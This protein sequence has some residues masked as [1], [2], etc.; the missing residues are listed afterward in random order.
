MSWIEKKRL[1]GLYDKHLLPTAE[2]LRSRDVTFFV[3]GPEDG[4]PS[5]P[6]T[7]S[8]QGDSWYAEP[9]TGPQLFRRESAD[10][11]RNLRHLWKD[12]P[13]LEGLAAPLAK[14]AT[15]LERPEE[16][17]SDLSPFVYVLY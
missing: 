7:P 2:R 6:P 1:T 11:E 17:A 9:P 10:L 13:E 12:I 4:E 5:H 3:M 16:Q 15:Q 14:L 8:A